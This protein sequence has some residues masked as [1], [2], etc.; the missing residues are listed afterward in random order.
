MAMLYPDDSGWALWLWWVV[1]HVGAFALIKGV[2]DS[3][4]VMALPSRVRT[5]TKGAVVGGCLAGAQYLVL[6]TLVPWA[7]AWAVVTVVGWTVGFCVGESFVRNRP[8]GQFIFGAIVGVAQ[9][10]VLTA[11]V[12]GWTGAWLAASCVS[13]GGSDTALKHAIRNHGFPTRLSVVVL[14][15][16]IGGSTG[17][18]LVWV[19]R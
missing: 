8:R 6:R 18:L 11:H 19:L 5:M 4:P 15:V 13:I 16:V 1:A 10:L 14:G 17:L 2:G 12:G 7:G 3:R 9:A